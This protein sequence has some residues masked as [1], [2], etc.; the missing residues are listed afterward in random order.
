MISNSYFDLKK[1]QFTRTA[2]GKRLKKFFA[3]TAEKFYVLA[4]RW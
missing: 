4:S 2:P 1:L 3:E